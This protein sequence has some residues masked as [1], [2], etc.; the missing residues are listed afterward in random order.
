VLQS[1]LRQLSP[2]FV[3]LAGKSP[4]CGLLP[5]RLRSSRPS[6]PL[7]RSIRG[8]FRAF[9]RSSQSSGKSGF[10]FCG[11]RPRWFRSIRISPPMRRPRKHSDCDFGHAR[12]HLRRIHPGGVGIAHVISACQ[13]EI[14]E[15]S[16]FRAA[17]S[18][19]QGD[20]RNWLKV[21]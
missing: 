16:K 17:A 12:E 1:E 15:S 21:N 6:R 3:R 13:G 18:G 8:S 7:P 9:Q 14:R 11:G 5:L 2:D 19:F 20:E 10:R 4:H